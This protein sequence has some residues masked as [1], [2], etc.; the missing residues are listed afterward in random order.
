MGEQGIGLVVNDGYLLFAQHLII[1]IAADGW[2]A[3]HDHLIVF[4]MARGL[5]HGREVVL[6]LLLATACEQGD[7]RL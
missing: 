1:I 6:D 7:D 5:D 2:C 4:E 3:R